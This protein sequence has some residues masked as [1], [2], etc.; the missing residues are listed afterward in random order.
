VPEKPATRADFDH[1]VRELERR[2]Y[3]RPK[4]EIVPEPYEVE[5]VEPLPQVDTSIGLAE[6]PHPHPDWI[7]LLPETELLEQ[8]I[9]FRQDSPQDVFPYHNEDPDIVPRFVESAMGK[10]LLGPVKDEEDDSLA[11]SYNC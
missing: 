1:V 11:S 6:R 3:S 10:L 5:L 8:E 2:L 4:P 7:P 9:K